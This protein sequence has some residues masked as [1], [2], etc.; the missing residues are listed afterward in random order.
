MEATMLD[1]TTEAAATAEI[2]L[3]CGDLFDALRRVR[4]AICQKETRYY[5][6]GVYLQYALRDDVL[7]F[8]ATDGHRL[9]MADIPAPQGAINVRPA[10]LSRAFVTDAIKATNKTRDVFK[11]VHLA[12]GPNSATLTDWAGSVIEGALVDGTFPDY[13]RVIPRGE[14]KHGAA[15]LAREPFMQAVAAVTA[16]AKASG[17]KRHVTPILRFAFAGEKLTVSAAIEGCGS[18]CHGT[19]SVAVE[20]VETTIAEPREI[21]FYGPQVLDILNSLRG[22]HVR[23]DLFDVGG[24]NNFVGDRA[25]NQALYVLM[26]V[27]L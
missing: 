4:H 22:G 11:Q 7:R 10:I 21:G 2:S 1:R 14:P 25:D 6:N 18:A 23:F 3:E 12:V 17:V 27:R 5:L 13:E 20:V 9:A 26:P 16:F 15:R 24:P 19:A 8:V